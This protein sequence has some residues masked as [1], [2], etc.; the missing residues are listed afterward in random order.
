MKSL[1]RILL[2]VALVLMPLQAWAASGPTT[3]NVFDSGGTAR[4]VNVYSS[5]G[6]VTGNL[7][8]MNTICD[9]TTLTTCAAVTTY[10]LNVDENS[11]SQFH[12]DLSA[13]PNATYQATYGSACSYSSGNNAICGDASGAWW[14][15][16]G[17]ID[18]GSAIIGKVGIDQTTDGTTNGVRLT[19]QYPAGA[20]PVTASA[21]GT[22]VTITASLPAVASNYNFVC[23]Y[24]IRAN[25]AAATTVAD[26]LS[27]VISGPMSSELWVAPA[28]SGLGVDEQIFNPCIP[29]SAVNTA[30]SAISG[31][32]GTSG[33]VSSKIWGYYKT[34]SP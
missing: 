24:S 8:W 18:A 17:M 21:T 14:V 26:T 5:T 25:A 9:Y 10:G 12:T 11:G 13:P 32:P 15:H 16:V 2:S 29:G 19:T 4:T 27:G 6:A 23:G 28:A 31:A 7:S 20:T 22:T 33:L 30:I 1:L 34:T 3:V